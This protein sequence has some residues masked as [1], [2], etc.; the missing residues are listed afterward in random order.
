MISTKN[1]TVTYKR[2]GVVAL[3]DVN[4]AIPGNTVTC[5][6]GPNASGKTTLLK[7]IAQILDYNGVVEVTGKDAKSIIK[8]LRRTLSYSSILEE[9]DLLGVT[10]FDVLLYSRYPVSRGFFTSEEDTSK[11]REVAVKLGIEGLLSR[12]LSELS[13]GELQRVVLAAALVKEP[14]ILLLDEPDSHLDVYSKIWLS[15]FLREISSSVTV[16]LST[17]D[18]LFASLTCEYFVV[19][20]RGRVVFTGSRRELLENTC[21][22]GEVYGVPFTSTLL[23]DLH[24]LIPLHPRFAKTTQREEENRVVEKSPVIPPTHEKTTSSREDFT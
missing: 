23:G 19:L 12:K 17:H 21:V 2:S 1:L 16:V 20:S 18:P 8:E 22:L 9:R 11:T 6:L 24:V 14:R 5:I 4:I 15:G 13:A 7:A 3:R 10:V